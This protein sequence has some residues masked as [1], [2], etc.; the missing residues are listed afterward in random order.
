MVDLPTP[1]LPEPIRKMLVRV[2]LSKGLC[3]R[4]FPPRSL[5]FSASRSAGL[6]T[7]SL[8]FAELT[9]ATDSTA[10][11]DS[12]SILLAAGHPVMV[13]LISTSTMPSAL[14]EISP[15]MSSSVR[16]MRSSG[17][18]TLDRASRMASC[19]P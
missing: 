14:T 16:G 6:M 10:C 19:T 12:D 4:G 3:L 18:I 13:S 9:P 11:F 15:T 1:P 8:M 5:A 7:V 17:S 2:S